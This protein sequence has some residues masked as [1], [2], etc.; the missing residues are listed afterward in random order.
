MKGG[1]A[2]RVA[3]GGAKKITEGKIRAQNENDV[4]LIVKGDYRDKDA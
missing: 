3:K 1:N 4:S 2:G